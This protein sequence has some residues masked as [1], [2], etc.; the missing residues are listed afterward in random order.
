MSRFYLFADEAG[1]FDFRRTTDA[2]RYF[3]LTSVAMAECSIA[4]EVLE[5]QRDLHWEG[6]EFKKGQF[7]A[8]NDKQVVRDAM[9]DLIRGHTIRVDST[10][11]EKSKT[12]PHLRADPHRFYKQLWY[13]H[14]KFVA[15]KIV[16]SADELFVVA[17]S[18]TTNMKQDATH[19]ALKDVVSQ[20]SAVGKYKT[21]FWPAMA[22]PCLQVA[23]YCSWAIQ[24][25]WEKGDSRSHLLIG[26]KIESEFDVFAGSG[27]HYY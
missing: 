2:S 16:N 23:D 21:A 14:L 5:L 19:D 13:L 25:K 10:I 6:Y 26:D 1:N 8:A 27:T 15:P 12:Q 22:E 17:A 9:F 18:I 11:I 7:H 3:I 20:V 24:R 4:A